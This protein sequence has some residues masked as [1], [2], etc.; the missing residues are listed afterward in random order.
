MGDGKSL[1]ELKAPYKLYLINP[2]K[3]R[4][5]PQGMK[6][7]FL[8]LTDDRIRNSNNSCERM[9]IQI[10]KSQTIYRNR[11]L[12]QNL[13]QSVQKTNLSRKPTPTYNRHPR[14]PASCTLALPEARLQSRKLNNNFCNN[15]PKIVR[16]WSR[17]DSL[18]NFCPC[19]QFRTRQR[20]TNMHPLTNLTMPYIES[21]GL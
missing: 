18:P 15:W 5:R 19:F 20:K 16:T 17:T 14:K 11:T 6:I 9:K 3:N 8:L 13:K 1:V 4:G 7:I 10:D 2:H 12:T 21:A